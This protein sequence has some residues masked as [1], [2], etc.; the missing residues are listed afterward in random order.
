N[1][2]RMQLAFTGS[3]IGNWAYTTAVS[4]WAYGV[5]GAKAVGIY[6]AVR[7]AVMALATPFVSTFADKYPRKLVMICSDF[8]CAGLITLATLCLSAGPPALPIFVL[9]TLTSFGG[10]S[11]R[12]AQGAITPQL[13]RTP[14]ELTASNGTSSTLESL[15]IFIGPAIGAGL[16]AIADV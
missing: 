2:R 10:S 6:I 5:G 14:A 4:V 13:A 9:A 7:M 11:F 15:A 16:L 12:A 8:Y 1:L 3:L